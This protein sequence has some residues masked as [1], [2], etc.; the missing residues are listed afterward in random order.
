MSMDENIEL[1]P[2]KQT[3]KS[4]LKGCLVFGLIVSVLVLIAI[5]IFI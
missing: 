3:M 2:V 4:L 1:Y 5:I